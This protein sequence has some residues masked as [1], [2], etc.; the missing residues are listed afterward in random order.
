[1]NTVVV[2]KTGGLTYFPDALGLQSPLGEQGATAA[3][4]RY[5]SDTGKYRVVF[6]GK[7]K[8]T[9]PDG[10]VHVDPDVGNIGEYTTGA[11]HAAIMSEQARRL[12]ELDARLLVNVCGGSPSMFSVDNPRGVSVFTFASRYCAPQLGAAGMLGMPRLCYVNDVRCYPRES[13]M[14]ER[15][16]SLVPR[17]LGG[18]KQDAWEQVIWRK[19]YR[20]T[21]RLCGMETWHTYGRESPQE[22]PRDVPLLLMG[23]CHEVQGFGKFKGR[24]GEVRREIQ[25]E[26]VGRNA[27]WLRS[28]G[29]RVVGEGWLE[30]GYCDRYDPDGDALFVGGCTP[31]LACDWMARSVCGLSI[32][33]WAKRPYVTSKLRYYAWCGCAPIMYGDGDDPCSGDGVGLYVPRGLGVPYRVRTADEL[34]AAVEYWNGEPHEAH[35]YAARIETAT[36]PDFSSVIDAIDGTL[37]GRPAGEEWYDTFGGFTAG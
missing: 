12:R 32:G 19:N 27:D 36:R 10:V 31:A 35:A 14:T 2:T 9:I 25:R 15:W 26:L 7:A 8:G 3:L 24:V 22:R 18:Q 21:E 13:E 34:R 37:A 29:A 17:V 4:T 6:H 28:I 1:M 30:A 5:L 33:P 16:P 23:H 11:E 20:V